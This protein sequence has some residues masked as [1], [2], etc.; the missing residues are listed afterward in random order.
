MLKWLKSIVLGPQPAGPPQTFRAFDPSEP[1][2]SHDAVKVENDAF[3]VQANQDTTVTLFE[4]APPEMQ[5]C[6][7]TYRAKAKAEEVDGRAY[8]EML[9]Q[10]P[11]IGEH[12]AKGVNTAVTGSSDWT[13]LEAPVMLDV[14]QVPET[15]RL[16]VVVEGQGTVRMKDVEILR[17]PYE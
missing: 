16:N 1:T 15:L 8:L 11:K 13:T 3:V 5:R 7:L 12:R 4:V 10:F 9:L 14:G 17:T 6:M 2:V